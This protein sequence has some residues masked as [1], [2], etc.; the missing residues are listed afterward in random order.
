MSERI[1]GK[2]VAFLVANEG[3]EQ[4]ELTAP[5]EAVEEA[6]GAPVLIGPEAGEVQAF[7]HLDKKTIAD[8]EELAKQPKFD[9]Y[10]WDLYSKMAVYYA[11]NPEAQQWRRDTLHRIEHQRA[12]PRSSPP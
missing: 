9:F 12:R 6:G 8:V 4:V 2:R 3:V 1:D 11:E 7:E 5:W 10:C